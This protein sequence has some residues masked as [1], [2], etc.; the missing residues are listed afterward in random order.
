MYLGNT[1]P[2]QKVKPFISTKWRQSAKG[3]MC[4][5]QIPGVCNH[6]PETTVL[7]HLRMFGWAGTAEKPHDFL[8]VYACSACH[9]A[10]ERRGTRS[11]ADPWDILQALGE[12]L[13]AHYEEGRIK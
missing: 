10:Q 11:G 8:A 12:T 7:C 3:K 1:P 13:T 2:R 4:R 9:E 5:L 6:N